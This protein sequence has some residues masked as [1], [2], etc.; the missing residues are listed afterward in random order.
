MS[1][2]SPDVD[3]EVRA[4]KENLR[5][6]SG[7]TADVEMRKGPSRRGLWTAVSSVAATSVVN[8]SL[9]I[10]LGSLLVIRARMAK[11]SQSQIL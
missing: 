3:R 2:G 9:G 8:K 4:R 6:Q 11:K 7:P 5:I 10:R 1:S